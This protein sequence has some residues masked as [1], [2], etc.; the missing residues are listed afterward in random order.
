MNIRE[1]TNEFD[2]R[3]NKAKLHGFTLADSCQGYFLLNQAK[4]SED[5]KKLIRATIT[6]LDIAEVK[7]KL[8]K[9]FGSGEAADDVGG[10]RVKVEDVNIAE[11]DVLYGNYNNRGQRFDNSR[12]PRG[13]TGNFQR[14][15]PQQ[16]FKNSNANPSYSN[17]TGYR[18]KTYGQGEKKK[19]RCNICE[20][21]NHLS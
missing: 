5:H 21:M 17:N 2:K 11:E 19:L 12:Y 13:G 3:Y 20:S 1:Y 14:R 6:K 15:F 9:V 4:L 18:N 8:N 7:T 10:L 16:G